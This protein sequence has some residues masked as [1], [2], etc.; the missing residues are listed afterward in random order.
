MGRIKNFFISGYCWFVK[1]LNFLTPAGDLFIRYWVAMAFF[2]SGLT[3]IH[4]WSS[5]L[6]LFQYEYQVPILS[7][8]TAA[9]LGTATELIVPIFLLLGLGGRIPGFILFIFNIVAVYSYRH[10]LFSDAGAA[11]LEDHMYW[12]I[13][14]AVN[15]LHGSGKLSLDHMIWLFWRRYTQR[16]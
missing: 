3:K 2:N 12:G 4:T 9:Y 6:A 11:G 14:L 7:P 10:I 5:T 8:E 15:V 16:A 1:I 13:L